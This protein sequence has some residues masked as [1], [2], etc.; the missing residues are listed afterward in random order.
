MCSAVVASQSL[1][2]HRAAMS[3]ANNWLWCDAP[4]CVT[5]APRLGG[6]PL[7]PRPIPRD[8]GARVAAGLSSADACRRSSSAF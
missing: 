8:V 7:R 2:R 4:C 6:G 1:Q 5:S 3:N